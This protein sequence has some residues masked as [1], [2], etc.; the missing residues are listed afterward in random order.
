MTTAA[1]FHT[2]DGITAHA[3]VFRILQTLYDMEPGYHALADI[4]EMS[5]LGR[6]TVH[7]ILQAG[8]ESGFVLQHRSRYGLSADH[9]FGRPESLPR[10]SA[11]DG[12]QLLA[13]ETSMLQRQT[14]QVVL[15]YTP[16]LV[17]VPAVRKCVHHTYGRRSDFAL[18]VGHNPTALAA[19][20]S[21]PL[22]A[23]AAGL[24]IL[25]HLDGSP[26][27]NRMEAIR[28]EGFALTPSIM[29]GWEMIGV[30]LWYGN[31]VTGAL[32]VLGLRGQIR[33]HLAEFAQAARAASA[34]I[35]RR[36]EAA[37]G[38]RLAAAS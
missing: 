1:A 32:A 12:D 15:V 7:R 36:C 28:A 35:S 37:G 19:L 5:K 24:S 16:Q 18:A 29:P 26:T 25:A 2:S 6:S 4:V 9:L 13:R 31:A 38:S 14:A 27:T 20:A 23:D 22:L 8:L 30:P 33:N 21:A 10:L 34:R 17:D 3:R 11:E